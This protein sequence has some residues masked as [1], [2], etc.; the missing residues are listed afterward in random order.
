MKKYIY[1]MAVA[2]AAICSSC[3]KDNDVTQ[4]FTPPTTESEGQEVT[5]NFTT[6]AATRA[7]F[8][9]DAV[10]ESWEKQINKMTIF[11]VRYYVPVQG[12]MEVVSKELTASEI[13]NGS[14][15]MLLESVNLNNFIGISIVANLDVPDD[16]SPL[17]IYSTVI[18]P[19][20]ESYYNGT[21]AE[22]SAS[23]KH[24]YGFPMYGIGSTVVTDVNNVGV[25]IELKRDV[26]KIAIETSLS[27]NFNNSNM[28][29]GDLRIDDITVRTSDKVNSDFE[30]CDT[31]TQASNK[32]GD[33]YQNLFYMQASYSN[34]FLV[35]ATY[36]ADGDFTTT[37]DQKQVTY[38]F[39]IDDEDGTNKSL[40]ANCYYRIRVTVNTL[41]VG[42]VDLSV[43]TSDWLSIENQA[44]EIAE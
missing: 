2:I 32:S 21:F 12:V 10:A 38:E 3:S 44:I 41:D 23:A 42:R 40:V 31:H 33:K 11:L 8:D 36:D 6:D 30:D 1:M 22:V 14:V 16:A 18:S 37:N 39:S 17:N 26:S 15:T 7:F 27:D 24:N 19:L 9:E 13:A 5:I 25:S 4:S 43:S 35:N 29:A 34:H 20:D 28:Y